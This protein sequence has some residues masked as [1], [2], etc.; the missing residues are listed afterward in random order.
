MY[1]RSVH[2]YALKETISADGVENTFSTPP[3]N[4]TGARGRIRVTRRVFVSI[5][6]R[7]RNAPTFAHYVLSYTMTRV[8]THTLTHTRTQTH[9]HTHAH[10]HTHK[11]THAHTLSRSALTSTRADNEPEKGERYRKPAAGE[12]EV[13]RAHTIIT[14]VPGLARPYGFSLSFSRF[15]RV[16]RYRTL[17]CAMRL[18][19]SCAYTQRSDIGKTK[20]RGLDNAPWK[21]AASPVTVVLKP[22]RID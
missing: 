7:G 19:R 6:C 3:L 9:S 20:D 14:S 1:L 16:Y 18:L 12:N 22:I 2:G 21:K 15:A 5:G 8:H 10:K 4:L 13:A 17:R 11:H